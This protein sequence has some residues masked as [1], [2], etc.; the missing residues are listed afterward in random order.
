MKS[1]SDNPSSDLC[2][3]VRFENKDSFQKIKIDAIDK[4]CS[5]QNISQIDL[6]KIDTEGHEIA[7]LN[8]ASDL[9][10]S[11]A[12]KAIYLECDFNND[13]PQ[14]SFFYDIFNY[15]TERSFAFHGLFGC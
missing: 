8:G 14:H 12:I 2:G 7:V 11:Y 5:Q 4:F 1:I 10:N 3:Q 9:I 6:L 15:L 13:D